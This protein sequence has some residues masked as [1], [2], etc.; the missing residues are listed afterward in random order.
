MYIL[1]HSL[2]P[3]LRALVRMMSSAFWVEV[4]ALWGGPGSITSVKLI[5][6]YPETLQHS[7]MEL[8]PSVNHSV[9]GLGKGIDLA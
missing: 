1:T 2:S 9:S 7:W 3:T 4:F 6:A 5:M 8:L